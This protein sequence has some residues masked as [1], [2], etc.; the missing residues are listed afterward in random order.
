VSTT[1]LLKV[2][3]LEALT[4]GIFAIAMT[5]LVLD[6]HLPSYSH[7]D[8]FFL[9]KDDVLF[10]LIVYIGSFI[11]LGT[12]WVAMNF[13]LGLLEKL[14]RVYVWSNI[15]YLMVVCVVPF[16]ASLVSTFPDSPVSIGFFGINLLCASLG[17]LLVSEAAHGFKLNKSFYNAEIRRAV[18]GRILVA[19]LFYMAALIVAY[20]HTYIAFGLLVMPI[21]IYIFP[22][23]VDHYESVE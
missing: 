23:K 7:G 13:Q 9:L 5:I 6:L 11:I 22:G 14:N 3:R 19:P 20:W 12:L 10:R 2:S 17:Q 15:L 21:L 8:L 18:V 1:H 4:D 16:S